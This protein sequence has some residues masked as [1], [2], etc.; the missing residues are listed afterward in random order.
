MKTILTCF[1][2]M[3]GIAT[4]HAQAPP[5]PDMSKFAPVVDE[6][7]DTIFKI[8]DVM[9][10]FEGGETALM[11]FV[12][13]HIFYPEDAR[14]MN[15]QGR[16]MVS[17]VTDTADGVE[18]ITMKQKVWPSM[19]EEAIRVVRLTQ[20]KWTPGVRGGR[21]V[22]VFFMLPIVMKTGEGDFS[23][24]L[25]PAMSAAEKK[26][27]KA[28]EADKFEVALKLYRDLCQQEPGNN[29]AAHNLGLCLYKTGDTE[30]ALDIW[31]KLRDKDWHTADDLIRKAGKR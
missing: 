18:N 20:G 21:K 5:A 17:F 7:G 31:K 27:I 2:I 29:F 24:I 14:T 12:Q 11:K 10:V 6:H 3:T 30:A 15:I 19:D 26:A 16:L 23:P 8:V 13:T 4:A 25:N 1:I 28:I 22:R 9:P